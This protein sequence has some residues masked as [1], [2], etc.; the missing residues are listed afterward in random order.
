MTFSQAE[1]EIFGPYFD[2]EK[3][4]W[5]DPLRVRRTLDMAL[6]GRVNDYLARMVADNPVEKG[7]AI[8]AVIQ[9]AAHAFGLKL[10]DP[11]TGEGVLDSSVLNL[12]ESYTD[13]ENE[14]K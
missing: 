7:E 3:E 4:R 6:A 13:W 8:N 2:G 9:A 11:E 1:K 5:A 10:F 12:M 14:K